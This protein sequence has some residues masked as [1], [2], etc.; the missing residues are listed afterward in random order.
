MNIVEDV[1]NLRCP[2]CKTVF[3]DFEG[4]FALTCGSNTCRRA[5]CAWCLQDCG[6]DAHAH[7]AAC[8]RG[9]GTYFGSLEEFNESHRQRQEQ[10][11]REIFRRQ[12]PETLKHLRRLMARD[13]ADLGINV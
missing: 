3:T 5:F 9:N 2:A 4:C 8:G 10:Q 6:H 13:L 1:L 12:G 7:V 11:V